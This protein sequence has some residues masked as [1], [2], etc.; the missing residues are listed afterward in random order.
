MVRLEQ[1]CK[2]PS[3][4][5]FDRRVEGLSGPARARIITEEYG[6]I[7]ECAHKHQLMKQRGLG[8]TLRQLRVAGD[9]WQGGRAPGQV[10]GT[11]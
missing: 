5:G 9:R 4:S 6:H 11:S 8:A 7:T 1:I 10:A 2:S 3:P